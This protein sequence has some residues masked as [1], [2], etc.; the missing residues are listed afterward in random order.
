MQFLVKI[1][2]ADV[3]LPETYQTVY[4]QLGGGVKTLFH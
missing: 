4:T 1:Y 2:F 3:A